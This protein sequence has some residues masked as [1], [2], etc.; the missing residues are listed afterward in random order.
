MNIIEKYNIEF[1]NLPLNPGMMMNIK[2]G[3]VQSILTVEF[4]YY[5][6]ATAYL[7]LLTDIIL[8]FA[9]PFAQGEEN[10]ILIIVSLIIINADFLYLFLHPY[11]PHIGL[12][13]DPNDLCILL[14][15]ESRRF[16]LYYRRRCIGY[17][18][19]MKLAALIFTPLLKEYLENQNL[20]EHKK[21]FITQNLEIW[22]EESEEH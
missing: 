13:P 3:L 10:I 14:D 22:I 18:G 20:P 9:L 19:K 1:I 17:I 2:L 11:A 7:R 21:Q 15:E 16:T 12:P 5:R 4:M 6:S 8:I